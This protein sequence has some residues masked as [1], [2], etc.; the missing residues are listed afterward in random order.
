MSLQCRIHKC[1]YPFFLSPVVRWEAP[2]RGV[3]EKKTWEMAIP[4]TVLELGE[5]PEREVVL[6]RELATV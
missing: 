6:R 4:E 5:T 2:G 1:S 3:G